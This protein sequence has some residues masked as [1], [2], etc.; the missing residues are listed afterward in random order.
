MSQGFGMCRNHQQSVLPP[1]GLSKQY[2][3]IQIKLAFDI[4]VYRCYQDFGLSYFSPHRKNCFG[5]I[6]FVRL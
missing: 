1:L 2:R 4:L 5:Y 3:H 6:S